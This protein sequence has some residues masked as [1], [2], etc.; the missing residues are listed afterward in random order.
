M[1]WP[2]AAI[3]A[4]V[5]QTIGIELIAFLVMALDRLRCEVEHVAQA[6]ESA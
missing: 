6:Q 5:A 4:N 1:A 3:A 2:S